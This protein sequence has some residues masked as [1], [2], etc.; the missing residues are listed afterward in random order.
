MLGRRLDRYVTSFFLWH[1]V[2][3][4]V[5]VLGLYIV[6]ETFTELD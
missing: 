1:F 2:L 6:V 4:L 3:V 5:A